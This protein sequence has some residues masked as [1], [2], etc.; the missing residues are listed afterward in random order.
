M[1]WLWKY[2]YFA[3]LRKLACSA[4]NFSKN[5]SPLLQY[6]TVLATTDKLI[7]ITTLSEFARFLSPL[8]PYPPRY[9]FT[10]TLPKIIMAPLYS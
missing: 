7:F 2:E 3:N 9:S 1:E 5:F 6:N 10:H 8:P 4:N